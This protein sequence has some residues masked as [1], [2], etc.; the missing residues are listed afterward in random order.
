MTNRLPQRAPAPQPVRPVPNNT[1]RAKFNAMIGGPDKPDQATLP[2]PMNQ[3][4]IYDS[5]QDPVRAESKD[6]TFKK[7]PIAQPSKVIKYKQVS[8]LV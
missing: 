4:R 3:P 7:M 1:N 2:Y 8:R 5:G 6:K